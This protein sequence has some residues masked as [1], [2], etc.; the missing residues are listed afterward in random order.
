MEEAVEE[1]MKKIKAHGNP[2]GDEG[3]GTVNIPRCPYCRRIF[4]DYEDMRA[5]IATHEGEY[6]KEKKA[7]LG[8]ILE[9]TWN[10]A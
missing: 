6:R 8:D 9:G 7:T 2:G 4:Y 1:A 10:H 3:D 5:H